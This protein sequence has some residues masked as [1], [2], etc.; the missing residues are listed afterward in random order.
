MILGIVGSELAKFTP[1]TELKAKLAIR[2]LLANLGPLDCVCSGECPLGGIDIWAIEEAEKAG[3]Q[4]Q[5]FP[6]KVH[7]WEDGYKPRNIEIAKFSDEVV[8]IV[9]LRL[10]EGYTGMTFFSCYHH[11][12]EIN[13]APHV[14]SGG[15]WTTKYARGLGKQSR[16]IVID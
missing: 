12:D 3:I 11:T 5:K 4:T 6:P 10:P 13:V 1:N 8:C 9:P 14:K 7:S 15:C 2:A 16:L